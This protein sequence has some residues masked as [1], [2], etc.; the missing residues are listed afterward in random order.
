MKLTGK[1]LE[2]RGDG[3]VVN[4]S[5]GEHRISVHEAGQLYILYLI[6]LESIYVCM[7]NWPSSHAQNSPTAG[8]LCESTILH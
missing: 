1:D 8:L 7:F 5:H 6:F 3:F 2:S 4:I